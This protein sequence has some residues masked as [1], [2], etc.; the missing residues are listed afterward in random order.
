[1]FLP[2]RTLGVKMRS[3]VLMVLLTMSGLIQAN[4]PEDVL[5]Q[6]FEVL[7][8]RDFSNLS[9]L[10]S[11]RNMADLKELADRAILSQ[12]PRGRFGLQERFFG[13]KVGAQAIEKTRAKHYLDVIAGEVLNAANAT[14]F[15][16][17]SESVLGRVDEGDDMVHFVAR[18]ELHQ[19]EKSSSDVMLY[20][21]VREN[22]LWKLTFPPTFKQI[23]SLLEASYK[24]M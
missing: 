12:A 2:A 10:M 20:T 5:H 13:H 18:L 16:V 11:E 17:D 14:H 19:D 15:M 3:L 1:G 23:L 4:E 7:T 21:L 8:E 24:R 9:G 6:Y 22:G